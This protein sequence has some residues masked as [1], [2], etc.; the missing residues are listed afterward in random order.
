MKAYG[1]N[2]HYNTTGAICGARTAF[3]FGVPEF[4]S[5]F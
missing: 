2:H 1:F 4:T 3:P 5:A